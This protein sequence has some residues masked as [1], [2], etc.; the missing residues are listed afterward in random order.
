MGCDIHVLCE[1]KYPGK[2]WRLWLKNPF[3]NSEDISN[4]ELHC[5]SGRSYMFF[6]ILAGVRQSFHDMKP[7]ADHRGLPKNHSK[8][9]DKWIRENEYHS[10]T[11]CNL[12]EMDRAIKRYEAYLMKYSD[13]YFFNI[14]AIFSQFDKNKNNNIVSNIEKIFCRDDDFG[15]F[16]SINIEPI[17]AEFE[18]IKAECE[19]LDLPKPRIRFIIG[20][21]S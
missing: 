19:F 15:N 1:I 6:G 7:I 16:K 8:E 17:K 2:P 12:R 9:V 11:W 18:L 3:L 10:I 13:D 21:D 5:L 4:N 20:F 14:D